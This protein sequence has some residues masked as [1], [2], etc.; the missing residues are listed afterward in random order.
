MET[1]RHLSGLERIKSSCDGGYSHATRLWFCR[2]LIPDVP[3]EGAIAETNPADQ[4]GRP[5]HTELQN[6][7][8]WTLFKVRA[9]L[10]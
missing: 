7:A 10:A 8:C 5:C 2:K 6:H 3:S 9:I 1:L 4:S